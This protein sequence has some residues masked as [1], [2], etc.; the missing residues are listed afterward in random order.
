MSLISDQG[1][2]PT[3]TVE[4]DRQQRGGSGGKQLPG[5]SPPNDT[6]QCA[7]D[8]AADHVGAMVDA[9]VGA[10]D[11]DDAGN[12][13]PDAAE[14]FPV[15]RGEHHG[16]KG[17]GTGVPAGERRRRWP[18]YLEAVFA[19]GGRPCALEQSFDALVDNETLCADQDREEEHLVTP[20]LGETPAQ[21]DGMPDHAEFADMARGGEDYL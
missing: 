11:A 6:E 7:N 5:D 9:D 10:A 4:Q 20:T 14:P 2:G 18:T 1:R 12:G 15:P 16:G 13:V 19:V 3:A 17:S 8:E 21:T